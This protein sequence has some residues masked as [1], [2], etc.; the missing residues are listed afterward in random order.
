M[1]KNERFRR[2]ARLCCYCAVNVAYYRAW[3]AGKELVTN[4]DFFVNAN[5]NALDIA[6]LDWCILFTERRGKHN[7]RKVV[8]ETGEFLPELYAQLKIDENC[9]EGHCLKMKTY[10]DKFLAHLDEDRLMHIP[11]LT[12]TLNSVVFLYGILQD[13]D[14]A[15]LNNLP[16]ELG[17]YYQ[18]RLAHGKR[19][20]TDQQSS[21]IR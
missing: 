21:T 12:I 2:V 11:D 5:S 10:R 4:D 16:T 14:A 19:H 15:L 17:Q 20:A 18:E 13:E 3:W 6:V 9:F 8:P 7:W 1:T